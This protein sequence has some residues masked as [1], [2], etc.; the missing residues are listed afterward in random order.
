MTAAALQKYAA[1][2]SYLTD[3]ELASVSPAAREAGDRLYQARERYSL[4][5]AMLGY[6]PDCRRYRQEHAEAAAELEAAE[7]A[8]EQALNRA[9][10]R[11]RRARAAYLAR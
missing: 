9:W 7:N 3:A 2:T 8:S 5:R 1:E 11:F 4:S 6:A 10:A